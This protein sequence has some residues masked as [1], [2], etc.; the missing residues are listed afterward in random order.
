ME[1]SS[2]HVCAAAEPLVPAGGAA[3]GGDGEGEGLLAE[4]PE[5]QAGQEAAAHSWGGAH[6]RESKP[7]VCA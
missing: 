3:P 2:R 6:T 5:A 4:L 1:P 7:Y